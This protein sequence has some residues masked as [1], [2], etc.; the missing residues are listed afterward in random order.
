MG[1]VGDAG[2]AFL[3]G[4]LGAKGKKLERADEK[5]AELRRSV[6]QTRAGKQQATGVSVSRDV[7]Y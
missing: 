6:V 4:F 1:S 3:E 5:V 7:W 2:I